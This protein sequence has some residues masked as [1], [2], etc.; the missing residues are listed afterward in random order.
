MITCGKHDSGLDTS[1]DVEKSVCVQMT[2]ITRMKPAISIRHAFLSAA[3]EAV[4]AGHVGAANQDFALLGNGRLG[5]GKRPAYRSPAA[6]GNSV[7]RNYRAGF[8][9]AVALDYRG[10]DGIEELGDFVGERRTTGNK[11]LE[12][13]AERAPRVSAQLA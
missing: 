12:V 8:R 11:V 6:V 3:I 9:E 13:A 4:T 10:A 2:E 1:G 7:G 5:A